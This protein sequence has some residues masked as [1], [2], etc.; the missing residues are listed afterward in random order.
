VTLIHILLV[1][2]DALVRKTMMRFL[3]KAGMSATETSNGLDALTHLQQGTYEVVISDI[4]MPAMSGLELITAIRRQHID[5]KV[6]AMSG[7]IHPGSEDN[8][9]LA[10]RVGA[11]ASLQKPFGYDALMSA[12]QT[13]CDS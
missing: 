4:D 12:I 5:V 2:D 1:D 11:D 7:G 9:V 3:A 10:M 8:L 6:I 13:V